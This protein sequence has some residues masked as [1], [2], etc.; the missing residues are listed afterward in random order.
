MQY[1]SAIIHLKRLTA[2]QR[3]NF[4]VLS[5]LSSH[6]YNKSIEELDKGY[7]QENQILDYQTLKTRIQG[8]KEYQEIGGWYYAVILQAISNFRKYLSTKRYQ[9]RTP[10]PILQAKNLSYFRAPKNNKNMFPV[11]LIHPQ[12]YH[13][14][15]IFPATKL[16]ASF[17][18]LLPKCYEQKKIQQAILR[19]LDNTQNQFGKWQL[20]I[21]YQLPQIEHTFLKDSNTLG[22]DLGVTNFCTCVTNQGNSFIIDGR[23]LKSIIQGRC[24]YYKKLSKF[25]SNTKRICS[26]KY[27]SKNKIRDY[28]NKAIAYIINYCIENHIGKI[29]IGWG[30]HFQ[31]QTT[32][33]GHKSN[34]IFHYIP[35]AMFTDALKSKCKQNGIQFF[36]IDESFTSQASSLDLDN[37]PKHVTTEKQNFSG[38]RRYRGLYIT[39]S[40]NKINADIN[41]A[42]N[43]LRKSNAVTVEQIARLGSRG[44][45]QP[46][47]IN[48]FLKC[49][50]LPNEKK[51][52]KN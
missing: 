27:K 43:I 18:I 45:E 28:L 34:Q 9:E 13:N 26:L 3:G 22:I 23:K 36:R 49:S 50:Q 4:N 39:K 37:I 14:T 8:S 30:L 44:L 11:Y 24:K 1:G 21:Q 12:R 17:Q 5:Q 32:T 19:S 33:L 6:L 38:H 25:G 15:I 46:K 2:S 31:R 40:G 10:K 42:L 51:E 47:R 35:F 20:V 16:T 48:I 41:G 52:L 7:R 29:I